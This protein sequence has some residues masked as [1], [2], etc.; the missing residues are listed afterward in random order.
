MT[1]QNIM[2]NI[3]TKV[4]VG[5]FCASSLFTTTG[6]IDETEPTNIATEEQLA[7][8]SQATEAL[9]W[10]IPAY[11][12]KVFSYSENHYDF[13]YGAIM[14]IRDVMTGDMAVESSDYDVWF[15]SWHTNQY[16][17]NNYAYAQF[18]W[19]YYWPFVQTQNNLIAAI[20]TTSATKAQ[21]GM[22]GAA[23]AYRALAYLEMSQM[24]EF[25][26]NDK[27]SSVNA[28]GND[29]LNLT[30]PIVNETTTEQEARN[31]P[32][33]HRDSIAKFILGDLEEA[34]KN[35][36]N[37]EFTSE[38]LPHL[39]AVYGLKARYYM[40]LG[41]Y[42]NAEK[43]ARL[44]IDNSNVTPMDSAACLD[45]KTG[46][47]QINKWM[48]GAQFVKE[49]DAV[50]TGIINWPSHLCSMTGNGY[51]TGIGMNVVHKRINSTLWE[52][53]PETDVRKGWWVDADMF[54]PNLE[55][56]YGT[57]ASA[58]IANAAVFATYTNV[59]FG[60]QD[61]IVFNT[62]NSQDWPLMRAEEMLLIQAE[63]LGRSAGVDAG[64]Q[65][66]EGFVKNYRDPAY[67]CT[68]TDLDAFV[69]EVWFQRRVELWG[70]GFSLFD[71]LRLKKPIIRK[72][73]NFSGNVT[74]EDLPAES[75]IFIY[76]IPESERE[77]NKGIDVSLLRE[78]PV[79]PKAIM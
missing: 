33:V 12:N 62:E 72:G 57:G 30:V 55:Y 51:T 16:Q 67:T 40:W 65:V 77:A 17:G 60:P 79:A 37:L 64:K 3:I 49:D 46:F 42:A 24:F 20:D 13:G 8:S 68:A 75:P 66:L 1:K 11:V 26:P 73:A 59:K 70:E 47:N 10:A 52:R 4:F 48:W 31:N 6:C 38:T 78:D 22:L 14:H 23:Q 29:V 5:V 61:N 56:A 28:S 44:A 18:I 21:L 7:S 25:L 9:L 32:R 39:D 27:T 74:F 69:D 43:Y 71:V 45:P 41:D 76:S 2:K 19:N 34:E 50:Q 35:I 15:N 58:G 53:I 54:S 36:V 63:A